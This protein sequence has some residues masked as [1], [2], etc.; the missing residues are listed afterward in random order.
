MYNYDTPTGFTE[1]TGHFTQLVWRGTEQMGCAAIDCG[2]GDSDGDG[3]GDS[4]SRRTSRTQ[5]DSTLGKYEQ[6]QGWYV[7]CEYSPAGNV[8]GSAGG[9]SSNTGS[10]G[11]SKV[12]AEIADEADV[13]D[14]A[15]GSS[16][17]SRGGKDDDKWFFRVNVQPSSTYSGPWPSS[18]ADEGGD[19]DD[20][21][22]AGR[23]YERRVGWRAVLAVLVIVAQ[24]L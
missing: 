20:D 18:T 15:A 3:D 10:S 23:S 7:V 22:R 8:V 19:E 16:S 11:R 1:E 2:F 4:K 9:S 17:G 14:V 13:V 5:K 6:A 21:S 12:A 24:L